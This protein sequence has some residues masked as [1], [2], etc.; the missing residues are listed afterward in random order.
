MT[1][2]A[3]RLVG[4]LA[5]LFLIVG[6]AVALDSDDEPGSLGAPGGSRP[7][8]ELGDVRLVAAESCE[9]L[10][11]FFREAAAVSFAGS[12]DFA[13]A[14]TRSSFSCRSCSRP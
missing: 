5:V 4:F 11:T 13:T 10:V 12:V 1:N 7:T 2:P 14:S 3:L 6:A 9:E 8:V